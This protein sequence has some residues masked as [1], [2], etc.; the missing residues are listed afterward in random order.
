LQKVVEWAS[1]NFNTDNA[2][3]QVS[4]NLLK[5]GFIDVR[6]GSSLYIEG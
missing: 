2:L 5:L 4:N 1:D 3:M 6:N